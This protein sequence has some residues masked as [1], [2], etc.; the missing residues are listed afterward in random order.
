MRELL[1]YGADCATLCF[2]GPVQ[3]RFVQRPRDTVREQVSGARQW[4][5]Y[6]EPGLPADLLASLRCCPQGLLETG[7]SLA[8]RRNARTIVRTSIAGRA[9]VV[10][11]F[12][13]RSWRHALKQ[14]VLKSRARRVYDDTLELVA[15]GVATPTPV[16]VYESTLG[17]LQR[18]TS[19]YVYAYQEGQ[20]VEALRTAGYLSNALQQDFTRA[21]TAMHQLLGRI[22]AVLHDPSLMNFVVDHRGRLWV[23][24]LDKLLHFPPGSRRLRRAMQG[25][26]DKFVERLSLQSS[27]Q[28][29][30][31]D[32]AS[33]SE[34]IIRFATQRVSEQRRVA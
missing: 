33:T 2:N 18:D 12:V 9:I 20:T 26:L 25:S 19:Y 23:I 7:T 27:E 6:H 8:E 31:A 24:D 28:N 32:D 1:A 4:S 3:K 30:D 29:S 15:A 22:G 13:E 21:A 14:T 34:A 5:M 16:A 10:K 17:P 11:R